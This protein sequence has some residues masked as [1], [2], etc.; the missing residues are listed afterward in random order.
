MSYQRPLMPKSTAV[1]L[2]ENTALTF[3]QIAKF[4]DIHEL[5]VQ[6]I[7]DQKSYSGIIGISPIRNGQLSQAQIDKCSKEPTL[8]LIMEREYI[9]GSLE[10][11]T[12]KKAR[13]TPIIRRQDKPSAILWLINKFPQIDDNK[14]IKLIGT[15]RKTIES[16]RNKEHWNIV[17]IKPK[18]PV[19]LGLCSQHD[20]N[21]LE[22]KLS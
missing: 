15:T 20:L 10:K 12:A 3:R 9:I 2:I 13:Y 5:E 6:A 14:I 8:D 7:A 21:E 1:W 17:N 18:D 11:R 22:K 16:I 19:V 4:C